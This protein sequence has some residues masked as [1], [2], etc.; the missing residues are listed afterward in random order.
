MP[1]DCEKT[2]QIRTC[3]PFAN[4][5]DVMN[6]L[7][8][9]RQCCRGEI[10]GVTNPVENPEAAL[11]EAFP[12]GYNLGCNCDMLI[13]VREDST[14]FASVDNG[15]SF[16]VLYLPMGSEGTIVGEMRMYGGSTPPAGWLLCDGSEVSRA[17]YANLFNVIGT[18]FG[19]GDG[20]TTFNLPDLRGRVP[21][22]LD[23]MGGTSANVV[24]DS[25][26][27][28]LGGTGGSETHTLILDELP[29][30]NHRPNTDA[31]FVRTA[32]SGN[33]IEVGGSSA[34]RAAAVPAMQ[35]SDQ[36]HNNMQPWLTV[37]YIIKY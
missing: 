19:A 5:E 6:I 10:A 21:M 4:Q 3:G 2:L 22:G 12:D 24:T 15:E 30:H 37:N 31:S 1:C 25:N 26:A 23:N 20:S 9:M 29:A 13:L 16:F 11:E 34:N 8:G 17:T 33:T 35:G 7:R 32:Q 14:V 18:A 27:D 36:P 28:V